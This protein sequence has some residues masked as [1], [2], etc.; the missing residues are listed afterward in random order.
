MTSSVAAAGLQGATQ[1][2]ARGEYATA[3]IL[4]DAMAGDEAN[5]AVHHLRA[6]IAAQQGNYDQAIS[7]WRA[8]LTLDA[9]NADAERGIA[10]AER[11]KGD[12][13][14]ARRRRVPSLAAT[15]MIGLFIPIVAAF[16][17]GYVISSRRITAEV[18]EMTQ[19]AVAPAEERLSRSMQT[20]QQT[21]AALQTEVRQLTAAPTAAAPPAPVPTTADGAGGA[22][23]LAIDVPGVSVHSEGDSLVVRFEGDLF[24]SGK[25]TLQPAGAALVAALGRQLRAHANTI[26]VTIIGQTDRLPVRPNSAFR[27]NAAL[28]LA[29]AVRVA[30]ALRATAEIRPIA[31][32]VRA[33]DNRP[34][35][36]SPETANRRAALIVIRARS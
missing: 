2:A 36:A 33:A 5:L 27:D 21:V 8:V 20:V 11:L 13:R 22:P 30:E 16:L 23:P 1:L 34:I 28:A 4:L 25:N 32:T 12:P 9:A 19:R 31:F 6:R 15:A 7:H 17:A 18:A 26:E 29:R 10:L 35:A 14:R 24:E 3:A